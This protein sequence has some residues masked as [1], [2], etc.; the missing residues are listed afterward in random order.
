[1]IHFKINQGIP[2]MK[3]TLNFSLL[4]ALS[5]AVI[6]QETNNTS[7]TNDTTELDDMV[8][9]AYKQARPVQEVVGDVSVISA[10]HLSQTLSQ[11][12][13][14]A[15]KYESNIHIED[16][17]TRFGTSGI[18]I[19]GI[20][21]NRV[22]IEIDGIPNAKT[23][24]LGSYSFATS[25]FPEIDLIQRVEILKGPASTLY[26]SDALGGI[27]SISTWDPDVLLA[28]HDDDNWNQLRIGYDGK[29]HGRFATISSAWNFDQQG[30][31]LS[32]TQS[33]G[34]GVVNENSTL[35]KD[36]ADWDSQ[37][38]FG[39]WQL[40]SLSGQSLTVNFSASQRNQLTQINSFIGQGRFNLTTALQGDDTAKDHQFSIDYDFS[41][42]KALADEANIT[43]YHANTEF[44]QDTFENRFTRQEVPLFQFR[45]F[46]FD[47]KRTGMEIN[48]TKSLA[49]LD[50]QH[51]FIY[52]MEFTQSKVEETR[53]A[54]ETNLNT[55]TTTHVV[56]G[57]N[58]PLRDFP[59]TTIKEFGLF[60]HDEITFTNPQWT[61][62]PAI[63]YDHYQLSPQRDS[64]FDNGAANAEVVNISASDFSPKLGLMYDL[65]DEINLYAQ[66]VRG[67]RAPPYDD[68]NIG[69]NL[70][71][72]NYQAI[73]NPTLK[74]ET[75][76]G[77]EVGFR[78]SGNSQQ[79]NL[80]LFNND[81][82]NL[83]VSRDLI[84][85]DPETQALIFQ[86]RNIDDAKIYGLEIDYQAQLN[87][88][89]STA[90]QLAWTRGKNTQSNQPLNHISPP[91]ASANIKWQSIDNKWH[92]G[93][94]GVF[95]QAM[96]RVNDAEN[97]FFLTPGY[98]TFD[99]MLSY[100]TSRNSQLQLGLFNMT[101]KKYWLW[102]QVRNF[103]NLDPIIEAMTQASRH[104]S[105]SFSV[106][107]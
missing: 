79:L 97:D 2:R 103:D 86:S 76:D 13:A 90:W 11:D 74:S 102:Q 73:P 32:A 96:K 42:N 43:I 35:A 45:Q 65:N 84:G 101:D 23:F 75:S 17:G 33:D 40:N 57:E 54:A 3:Y 95:S 47:S 52:G 66:Y 31:L 7:G 58:F 89:W 60:I 14:A 72:F 81:Y 69:F 61:L 21:N 18:N 63:R 50:T 107:W 83:I 87:S 41:V 12:M 37:S 85:L 10:D 77:F 30:L 55:G 26:G 1:M 98:A 92:A 39:K 8:V 62:V 19:R 28:N 48:M 104:T 15:V 100:Q 106:V 24:N 34:K 38:V 64:L 51:Q 53:D 93:L 67:F 49:L 27:V 9:V 36:T 71:L 6:A 59:I 99:L 88:Q 44:T 20:G 68:V 29:R 78:Y 80:S 94:Y 22:A 105:L 4:M 91:K 5:S 46:D 25:A 70:A 82:N 16:G 56:L